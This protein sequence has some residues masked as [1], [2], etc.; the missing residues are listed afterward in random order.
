MRDQ[1]DEQNQRER[2]HSAISYILF[3]FVSAPT[4]LQSRKSLPTQAYLTWERLQKCWNR[5]P[6]GCEPPHLVQQTLN[7]TWK[8]IL[9]TSTHKSGKARKRRILLWRCSLLF[10]EGWLEPKRCRRLTE[11]SSQSWKR[12]VS[13]W[14]GLQKDVQDW[15]ISHFEQLGNSAQNLYLFGSNN[16][17][18]RWIRCFSFQKKWF[19][20]G[21]CHYQN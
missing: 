19:K 4:L 11:K 9:Q 17:A 6:G 16:K 5:R 21:I 7:H 8:M 20:D 14:K 10:P 18:F 2:D 12:N 1:K 13:G 3:A 15:R